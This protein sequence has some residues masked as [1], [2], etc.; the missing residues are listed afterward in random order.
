[1]FPGAGSAGPWINSNATRMV[2]IAGSI[3]RELW[4]LDDP[5]IRAQFTGR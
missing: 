2:Y 1:V 3:R 5:Q 4:M